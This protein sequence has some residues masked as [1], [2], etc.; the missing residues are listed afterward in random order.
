M[1]QAGAPDPRLLR[2]SA[3]LLVEQAAR[4][5][6]RA[7]D[8]HRILVDTSVRVHGHDVAFL[9]IGRGGRLRLAAA[10]T[11][12]KADRTGPLV[13]F[14]TKAV[15]RLA[16]ETRKEPT[17]VPAA[18]FRFPDAD[19][20]EGLPREIL[21][22]PLNG[23]NDRREGVLLL[24]RRASWQESERLLAD[25]LANCYGHALWAR[26]GRLPDL[27][28][29]GT[30]YGIL[31]LL[32]LSTASLVPVRLDT[33]SPAEIVAADPVPVTAPLDGVVA[34]VPVRPYQ[35]VKAGDLLLAFD[36]RE[37]AMNR[38][39]AAKG[40]AVAEAELAALRNQAFLDAASKS[41]VNVAEQ[42]VALERENFAFA[43]ARFKRHRLLAPSD[44]VVLYDDRLNWQ[45]RP[46]STGEMLMTVATPDDVELRV[47]V[48]VNGLIPTAEGSEVRLFLDMD[49]SNPL[50]ARLTRLGYEARPQPG[51]GLSYRFVAAFD[52][53]GAAHRLGARGTAKVYGERVT[54][55]YY[56]LRR[57]LAAVRRFIGF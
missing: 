9:F 2:L 1:T 33:L 24:M 31:A 21:W 32:V 47:D 48:P 39:V 53:R 42:R 13:Q 41:Q 12:L 38:D 43:D 57:P 25:P 30:A 5:A 36:A 7:A 52:D 26:R 17:R 55:G 40:L 27:R 10:S 6:K 18:D 15:N 51:G 50:T 22:L 37:L 4:S 46:V 35:K 54:L 8:L 20:A 28:T 3:A 44:G 23:P 14:L 16:R 11:V 29:P 49:P 34:E 19:W 45:G 56:L